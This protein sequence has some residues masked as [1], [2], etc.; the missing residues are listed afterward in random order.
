MSA[1]NLEAKEIPCEYVDDFCALLDLAIK[2]K[3]A[4]ARIP[5][6]KTNSLIQFSYYKEVNEGRISIHNLEYYDPLLCKR[7]FDKTD[8][9]DHSSWDH[10]PLHLFN[11]CYLHLMNPL[12]QFGDVSNFHVELICVEGSVKL[13]YQ[14]AGHFMRDSHPEELRF[15]IE[16]IDEVPRVNER[17]KKL[18]EIVLEVVER[19]EKE[20]ETKTEK[21]C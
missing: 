9:P 11:A 18:W 5:N 1:V 10:N 17:L 20:K 8:Y 19:E 13:K 16:H 6:F 12:K 21:C 3:G 7:L 14:K 15:I 4:H 2:H